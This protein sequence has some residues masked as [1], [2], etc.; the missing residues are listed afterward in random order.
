LRAN[1][2]NVGAE[3]APR[4]RAYCLRRKLGFAHNLLDVVCDHTPALEDAAVD[5]HGVHIRGRRGADDR[6]LDIPRRG[7]VDVIGA[8]QDDVGALSRPK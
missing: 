3:S 6:G 4:P 2:S 7:D 5:H 8:N 1:S